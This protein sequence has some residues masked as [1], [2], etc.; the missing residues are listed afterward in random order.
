MLVLTFAVAG[1]PISVNAMYQR[2]RGKRLFKTDVG[3]TYQNLVAHKAKAAMLG[4]M[5]FG[6]CEV[7]LAFYYPS[8]R[9]DVDG[10]IKPALDALQLGGVFPNDRLVQR[11]VAAKFLDKESPR[12]EVRVTALGWKV[13]EMSDEP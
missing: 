4:C 6:E 9:N 2:G 7:S 8:R 11:L 10:A 13:D 3:R 12:L 1:T 5:P